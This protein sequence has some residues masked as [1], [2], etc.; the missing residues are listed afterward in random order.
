MLRVIG[1][2]GCMISHSAALGGIARMAHDGGRPC[3]LKRIVRRING[4]ARYSVCADGSRGA[5]CRENGDSAS[6]SREKPFAYREDLRSSVTSCQTSAAILRAANDD[7]G[8][9]K[10]AGR[11]SSQYLYKQLTRWHI[12]ILITMIDLSAISISH[13]ISASFTG[14]DLIFRQY[15]M[16]A[17][18]IGAVI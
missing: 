7:I 15:T 4:A 11:F 10:I 5:S 17:R 16:P 3:R 14:H 13:F 18:L 12:F 8:H 9:D 2:R 1:D 6:S